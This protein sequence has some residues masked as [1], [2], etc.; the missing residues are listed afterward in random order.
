MVF[1]LGFVFGGRGDNGKTRPSPKEHRGKRQKSTESHLNTSDAS[2]F[3]YTPA[4]TPEPPKYV[5]RKSW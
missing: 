4:A 2:I 3:G 1:P 5:P